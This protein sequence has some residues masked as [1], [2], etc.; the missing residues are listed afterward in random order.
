MQGNLCETLAKMAFL[1]DLGGGN[2]LSTPVGQLIGK[3]YLFVSIC[4]LY[5]FNML[6]VC[7]YT[8]VVCNC[9]TFFSW[10]THA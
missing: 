8:G 5:L 6:L 2:P 9:K 4:V 1:R 7:G 3:Y 10:M